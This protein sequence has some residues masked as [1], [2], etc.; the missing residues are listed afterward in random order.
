MNIVQNIKEGMAAIQANILRS[1]LT[2]LIVAIGITSLVGIITAI[3]GIKAS[4]S[5]SF[6]DLG[7]NSFTIQV[8]KPLGRRRGRMQQIYPPITYKEAIEFAR[9]YKVPASVSVSTIITSVAEVKRLSEKT[10]PNIT[11]IAGNENYIYQEGLEIEKG[12]NFTAREV[13]LGANVAV[14][15][16]KIVETLFDDKEDPLAGEIS[17]WGTRYK[18]IGVLSKQGAMDGGSSDLRVIIPLQSGRLLAAGRNLQYDIDVLVKNNVDMEMA[19]GEASGLMRLVRHDPIGKESFEVKKSESLAATLDEVSGYLKWGGLGI[20]LIT[21]L[22]ASIGLMNIMMVSVTERTREIGI[23]KALGATPKLIRQQFIIEAIVVCQLGGI[24]GILMGIGIGNVITRAIGDEV[25]FVIPWLWIL[26][27][28]LLGIIVGV[29]SGYYP[30][31]K[32]SRLDP[33]ESLR[34]E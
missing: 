18:V 8:R 32:A 17:V 29:G 7:A 5:E 13:R 26:L 3:D 21:L 6:S 16:S 9:R 31:W 14:L 24:A 23:R 1:I 12:R 34:F 27:A 11:L 10:N 33:I 15:G 20:G 19:M 22:G 4:I 2:A 25:V 30:A 28:F